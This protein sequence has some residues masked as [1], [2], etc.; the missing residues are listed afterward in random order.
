MNVQSIFV[1][2]D[3][4]LLVQTTNGTSFIPAGERT[5]FFL[6]YKVQM[7]IYISV[8]GVQSM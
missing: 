8:Q 2:D 6:L 4:D 5:L 7:N 3:D 1:Q